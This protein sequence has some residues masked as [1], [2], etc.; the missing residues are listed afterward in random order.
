MPDNGDA[1]YDAADYLC[2]QVLKQLYNLGYTGTGRT[3]Y[4][5]L[6][7]ITARR[8]EEEYGENVGLPRH[9]Y[10]YGE[11]IQENTDI[12]FRRRSDYHSGFD[13][14]PADRVSESDFDIDEVRASTIRQIVT[15]ILAKHA[16]KSGGELEKYQYE[17]F[18]PNDFIRSYGDL[19]WFL[20]ERKLTGSEEQ[21]QARMGDYHEN[22]T[23]LEKRLDEMLI[24]F[25]EEY[26]DVYDL[27]LE[28]D[29]TMRMLA[30]RDI[31]AYVLLDFLEEF[32]DKLSKIELRF[33]YHENISEN[34]LEEWQQERPELLESLREEIEGRR[35]ELFADRD[36]SGVLESV[37]S[38]FSDAMVEE[39]S[40]D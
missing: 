18:A 10:K 32:I 16:D 1:V 9:W 34:K 6:S 36:S 33:R 12:A 13:Y 26:E 28:W 21:Y 30:H 7:T 8:L 37:S 23:E 5:K 2:Y 17:E 29:D 14:Y 19:R 22:Q 15:E 38:S 40:R 11:V 24:E 31:P 39:I 4:F 20:T 27:Y 3:K 25:P 35:K